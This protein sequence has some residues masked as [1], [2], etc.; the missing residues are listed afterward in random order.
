MILRLRRGFTSEMKST[1]GYEMMKEY[2]TMPDTN[3]AA[4]NQYRRRLERII[5]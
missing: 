3:R 4:T 1:L 5:D 2:P